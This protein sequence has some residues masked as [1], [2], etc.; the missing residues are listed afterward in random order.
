MGDFVSPSR[1]IK[2]AQ[3]KPR[4]NGQGLRVIGG[5][6]S[7]LIAFLLTL[8]LSLDV[9]TMSTLVRL[10]VNEPPPLVANG[11]QLGPG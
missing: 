1:G 9:H 3:K 10:D 11:I 5:R 7:L 4:Q 6:P 2:I 8:A